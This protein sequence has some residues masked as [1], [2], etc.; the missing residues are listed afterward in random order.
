M[1]AIFPTYTLPTN[2][3]GTTYYFAKVLSDGCN[4][5]DSNIISQTVV[6]PLSSIGAISGSS[7]L[8]S[9]ATHAT[10]SVPAVAGATGYVWDLPVGMTL[11]S[12]TGP[13]LLLLYLLHLLIVLFE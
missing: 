4:A 8:S 5:L 7:S 1:V 2:V 13:R 11:T 12:Q 6:N 10:Y 9:S 3:L